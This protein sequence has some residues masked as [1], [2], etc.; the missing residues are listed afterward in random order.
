VTWSVEWS[1][2]SE[3][4]L[5]TLPHWRDAERLAVAIHHYAATGVGELWRVPNTSEY[6]IT[7]GHCGARVSFDVK[8]RV[9]YVWHAYAVK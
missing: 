3:R 2:R 7:A 8:A 6:R 4:D 1:P 9:L 5:L